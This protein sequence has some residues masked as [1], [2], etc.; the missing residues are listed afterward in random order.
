MVFWKTC[1]AAMAAFL[2]TACGEEERRP[3]PVK[4]VSNPAE[5]VFET[6]GGTLEVSIT[7]SIK[8]TVSCP[9]S[10]VS[11]K[12]G[13]FGSNTFKLSVTAGE[14]TGTGSR[15]T[16]IRVAGDKQNLTIP[17][18]QKGVPSIPVAPTTA[19]TPEIV[20]NAMA[21]GWNMGNQM[22]AINGGVSGETAWGN[23]KCTQATMN[24]VKAAG[25]K[26]VRICVTWEGHVGAAP[27]YRIEDRWLDRVAEIVG[28]A[29]TAGLVAIVNT[30]H[31]ESNWQ[32][33]SK[34]YKDA[35]RNEKV[36]AE[37]AALWTQIAQRFKDKGDWLVFE[38]VNEI[39]DGGWGWSDDFKKNP[40]AQYKVLNEW[41]QVFVD[42]VRA[43]GGN[44][45]TRWLGIPGYAANP[46]FTIKGLKLPED[47]TDANRLMV[48]VHDY[49]PFDYTLKDPLVRQWGHTADP[50]K[51]VSSNDE[52]AVVAVF[53]NLKS[54]YLDKGIPVYLGEMGCSR[55][56]DADFPYQKYYME[57]FCKAAADR[58]L[59]MF[60]WD[61]GA[62]GI[63]SERHGYI[64]HGTGKLVDE[65][66]REL[67]DLMVK[68][69]TE[70]S[71]SYTLES[72]YNSAP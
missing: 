19:L 13:S 14:N 31:D 68:A 35:D 46:G 53:D 11:L 10:W 59:P 56:E 28:Y 45:A 61:N 25:F 27:G 22:D 54:A 2:L 37:M 51:R 71:S 15:S 64:D 26:A 60:L 40:D 69:V 17:V 48:A 43:T 49:D 72:V 9:D 66:A 41:N 21:P 70:K 42:A 16:S 5:L 30:H 62:T 47:H 8:P 50:D 3:D 7:T 1:L 57:Y 39:Q 6:A 44:N 58:R 63:G 29:E 20:F 4:L 65:K 33:I 23:P 12:E 38:S 36:K 24:G 32:D 34:A 67:V 18:T 52:Q 55:H